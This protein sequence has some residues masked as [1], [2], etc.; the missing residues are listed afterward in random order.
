M[1]NPK[2]YKDQKSFMGACMH[3]VKKVEGKPQKQAVAQCMNMWR[4]KGKTKSESQNNFVDY[5]LEGGL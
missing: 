2:K 4:R 5:Y 3:Q 1:P